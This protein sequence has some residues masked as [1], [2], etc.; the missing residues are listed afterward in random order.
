MPSAE[1]ASQG[2]EVSTQ[3]IPADLLGDGEIII[4]AIK[5]SPWF[6]LLASLPVLASAGLVV[7]VAYAVEAF[8]P[9]TVSKAVML[10]GVL[11]GMGRVSAACWQWLGR[12]YVLTNLRVV[13]VRGLLSVRVQDAPLVHVRQAVLEVSTPERLV[14]AGSIRCVVAGE[15]DPDVLW[16]SVARPEQIHEAVQEAISRA[17]RGGPAQRPA[18]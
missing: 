15:E 14:G 1:P 16:T 13:L 11:A 4:L 5:P 7:V 17:R 3:L 9:S 2:A 18:R 12:T 8:R 6:V 10:V